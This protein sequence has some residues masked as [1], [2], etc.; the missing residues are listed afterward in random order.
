MCL[1]SC[2]SGFTIN[3][4]CVWWPNETNDMLLHTYRHDLFLFSP[5]IEAKFKPLMAPKSHK[6]SSTGLLICLKQNNSE[7]INSPNC[8][9][10]KLTEQN[11]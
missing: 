6:S 1:T 7:S 11:K 4:V 3:F 9:R 5:N 2:L 10:G 8:T